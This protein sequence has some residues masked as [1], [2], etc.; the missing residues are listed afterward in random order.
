MMTLKTNKP[1]ECDADIA[2]VV[3]AEV[4]TNSQSKASGASYGCMIWIILLFIIGLMAL[5]VG[6]LMNDSDKMSDQYPLNAF[7]PTKADKKKPVTESL[8]EKP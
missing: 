7:D 2:K 1:S 5:T 8:L 3:H 4:K 6:V